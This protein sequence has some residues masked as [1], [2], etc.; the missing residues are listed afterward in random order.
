MNNHTKPQSGFDFAL[1]HKIFHEEKI[2]LYCS[3]RRLVTGTNLAPLVRQ[4]G[5]SPPHP[6]ESCLP[7][8]PLTQHGL[9]Y[10]PLTRR[11]KLQSRRNDAGPQPAEACG[12]AGHVCRGW[13]RR[14]SDWGDA[15]A[16]SDGALRGKTSSARVPERL[17]R[18]A[19]TKAQSKP[20]LLSR[21]G[22][23]LQDQGF[24]TGALLGVRK[25]G[26]PAKQGTP[27]GL[28]AR[29]KLWLFLKLHLFLYKIYILIPAQPTL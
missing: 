26:S 16:A 10:P 21:E 15:A 9:Q 3:C 12:G 19:G 11:Q 18:R 14:D 7:L 28:G 17:Q 1:P 5:C 13:R 23:G 22:R 25:E 29:G 24:S 8:L 4:M 20:W 2:I 6:P 27:K